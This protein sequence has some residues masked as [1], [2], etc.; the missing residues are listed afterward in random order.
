M[1]DIKST[2]VVAAIGYG[3]YYFFTHNNV[4]PFPPTDKEVGEVVRK[5]MPQFAGGYEVNVVNNCARTEGGFIDG[6]YTCGVEISGGSDVQEMRVKIRKF[7][8]KWVLAQ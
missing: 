7:Q 3:I 2:L 5:G 8:G 6:V 4:T 1:M